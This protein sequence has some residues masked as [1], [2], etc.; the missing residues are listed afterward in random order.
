MKN[1]YIAY[2]NHTDEDIAIAMLGIL[3]KDGE[4]E[5]KKLQT[6]LSEL[7]LKKGCN[8]GLIKAAG[9]LPLIER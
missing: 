5:Q 7:A 6:I 9:H 8:I 4:E 1:Y 2:A 3:A